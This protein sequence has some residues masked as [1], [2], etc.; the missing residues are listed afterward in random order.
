M[1]F[2]SSGKTVFWSINDLST[3]WLFTVSQAHFLALPK[4]G[5]PVSVGSYLS[6]SGN[7]KGN[8]SAGIM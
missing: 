4:G 3:T 7:S 2:N 1:V 8:L 5:S 6:I